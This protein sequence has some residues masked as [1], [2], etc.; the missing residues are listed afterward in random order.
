MEQFQQSIPYRQYIKSLKWNVDILENV[1][2]FRKNF[3][4]IGGFAKMQRSDH[5]PNANTF[6]K[7]IKKFR[8]NKVIIE[9][10]A[11]FPQKKLSDYIKKLKLSG[12]KVN[13]SPFIPT[14]TIRIDLT[15]SEN[16]IFSAF[17]EAK[18]RAVRKALKNNVQVEESD[19]ISDLIAIKNKSGGL[20]GFIT[21]S[22]IRNLWNI[23]GPKSAAILLAYDGLP[24]KKCVGGILLV[25]YK[26]VSF[27]WIAGAS[28][29]GK[30]IFA[31]TLLIWEALKLSKSRGCHTFDFVG[32]WDDRMPKE[33]LEWKG[34]TKFKEGFG[35]SDLYYPSAAL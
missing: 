27:Y 22:G 23:L 16:N 2:I 20:F 17:T 26:R 15:V 13:T 3:P 28:K 31:P 19:N 14:K 7:Y 11:D 32:V 9:P 1:A 12:I 33:N 25:M 18:R 8:I 21:T 34:F 35:G 5:L 24:G 4:L 29:Y 10:E 30:K 6:I